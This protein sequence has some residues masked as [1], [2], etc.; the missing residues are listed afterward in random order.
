MKTLKRTR[1]WTMNRRNQSTTPAYNLKVCNVIDCGLQ[2]KV[3]ELMECDD[4][5]DEINNLVAC[6]NLKYDFVWQAGFNGRSDGYLILLNGGRNKSGRIFTQPGQGIEEGDAP[7]NVLRA[8]RKL[9][10]DIVKTTEYTAKNCKIEEETYQTEETR[11]V[12]V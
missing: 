9:A 4:F 12:I 7:A 11:K 2:N 3:F 5:Y 8:F 6:F 1:Y 10:V